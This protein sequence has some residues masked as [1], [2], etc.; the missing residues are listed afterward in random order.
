MKSS[1]YILKTKRG[2]A[3]AGRCQFPLCCNFFGLQ[4]NN[5][6]YCRAHPRVPDCKKAVLVSKNIE[7]R[8]G[9]IITTRISVK[10]KKND[11]Q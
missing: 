5:R 10:K 9:W 3:I 8:N 4:Y 2:R 6:K 7:E 1:I 11:V